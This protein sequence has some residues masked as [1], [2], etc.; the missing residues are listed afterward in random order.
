[1][2]NKNKE[3]FEIGKAASIASAT[4]AT[5]ESATKAFDAMAGIPVAGPAL[6]IAAAAAAIAAGLINIDQIASQSFAKGSDYI[7]S[8]MTAN[9]HKGERI[10]PA[11]QN[12]PGVPNSVYSSAARQM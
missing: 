11:A 3:Q 2:K 1:M 6:G 4:I 9:I 8:D 10:I 7:P 5:Y 12:I